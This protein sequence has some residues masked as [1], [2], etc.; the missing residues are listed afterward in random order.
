M[1]CKICGVIIGYSFKELLTE[2]NKPK[3]S[4]EWVNGKLINVDT[5]NECLKLKPE[6]YNF[7]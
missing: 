6:R 1:K 2:Q 5:C 4:G 7:N 3:Q